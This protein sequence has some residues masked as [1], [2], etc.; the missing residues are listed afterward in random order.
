MVTFLNLENFY[1]K[2]AMKN[3]FIVGNGKSYKKIVPEDF[4]AVRNKYNEQFEE[5]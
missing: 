5:L 2:K 3:L 4:Q 1:F